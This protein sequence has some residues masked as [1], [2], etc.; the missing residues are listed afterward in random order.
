MEEVA[1]VISLASVVKRLTGLLAEPSGSGRAPWASDPCLGICWRTYG[2]DTLDLV[3]AQSSSCWLSPTISF[4]GT[5]LHR[6]WALTSEL[7]GRAPQP[8][9]F[10]LSASGHTGP[11][12][13]DLGH[14]GSNVEGNQTWVFSLPNHSP[15]P[16]L[17]AVWGPDWYGDFEGNLSRVTHLLPLEL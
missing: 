6:C 14:T 2:L 4:T 9:S 3:R 5:W 15:P 1:S 8:L 7:P 10:H 11:C 13:S 16:S 17:S 12:G